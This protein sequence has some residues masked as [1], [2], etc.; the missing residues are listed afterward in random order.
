MEKSSTNKFL[1]DGF[2]RNKDNLEGWV[3]EVGDKADVKFVL[4]FDCPEEVSEC[5]VICNVIVN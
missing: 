3:R 2:P 4:F 1:I 5:L